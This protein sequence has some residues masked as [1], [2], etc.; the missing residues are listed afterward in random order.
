MPCKTIKQIFLRDG[1]AGGISGEIVLERA[2]HSRAVHLRLLRRLGN[3]EQI[4]I[5]ILPRTCEIIIKMRHRKPTACKQLTQKLFITDIRAMR[6]RGR[7]KDVAMLGK[8]DFEL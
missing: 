6:Y 5:K 3:T 2:M 7:K 1:L 4:D 8:V